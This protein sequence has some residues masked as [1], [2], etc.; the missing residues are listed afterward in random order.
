MNQKL[1]RIFKNREHLLAQSAAQ[2]QAVTQHMAPLKKV[3]GWADTGVMVARAIKSQASLA[4]G[5][6]ALLGV[7]GQT[8][9][10]KWIQTGL[11]AMQFSRN[12]QRWLRSK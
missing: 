3:L 5:L 4:L 9:V 7:T 10:G 11:L 12:L 6:T 2:R 8:R 1:V